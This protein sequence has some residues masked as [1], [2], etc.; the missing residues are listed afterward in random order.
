M[1]IIEPMGKPQDGPD[2]AEYSLR[3]QELL[4]PT[5]DQAVE[6][7]LA[8]GFTEDDAHFAM[9]ALSVAAMKGKEANFDADEAIALAIKTIGQP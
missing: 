4:T 8:S 6:M 5:F 9:L 1:G 3:V 7:A 2:F